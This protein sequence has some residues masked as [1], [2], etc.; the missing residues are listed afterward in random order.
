MPD[1]VAKDH[2]GATYDEM[3]VGFQSFYYDLALSVS[4]AVLKLLLE[5]VPHDH[6]LYGS[7]FPYAPPP[8]YPAFLED[9][10]N[11]TMTSELRDKINF[12]NA[13]NLIPRLSKPLGMQP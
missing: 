1:A 7:D 10:E 12:S 2:I 5:N 9:L 13:I 11:S 6:I 4:P 3:M 8:A